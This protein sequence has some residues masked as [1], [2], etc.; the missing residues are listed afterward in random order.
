ML[1]GGSLNAHT[2]NE[3]G[4]SGRSKYCLIMQGYKGFIVALQSGAIE[5]IQ[6]RIHMLKEKCGIEISLDFSPIRHFVP[7]LREFFLLVRIGQMIVLACTDLGVYRNY[8]GQ[9]KRSAFVLQNSNQRGRGFVCNGF[10]KPLFSPVWFFCFRNG[11][12]FCPAG[13]P[14]P[15]HVFNVKA[16]AQGEQII[17]QSN[18]CSFR[19]AAC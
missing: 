7:P 1:I 5:S 14:L 10:S 17:C 16:I 13:Q 3:F 6:L 18:G 19:M 8:S 9:T 15:I 2:R 4:C 12:F 11:G